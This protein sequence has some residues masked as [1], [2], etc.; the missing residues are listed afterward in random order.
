MCT[1]IIS[2]H[3]WNCQDLLRGGAKLEIRSWGNHGE[4]QRRVQQMTYSSFVT[5]VVLIKTAASC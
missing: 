3:Q 5:N 4:L 2:F 1:K